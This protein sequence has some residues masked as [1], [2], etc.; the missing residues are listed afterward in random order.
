MRK[1]VGMQT[2]FKCSSNR[3]SLIDED[4]YDVDDSPGTEYALG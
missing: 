3:V 1:R 2:N 4:T